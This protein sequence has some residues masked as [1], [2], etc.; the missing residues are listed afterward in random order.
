MSLKALQLTVLHLDGMEE[1]VTIHAGAQ[2]ASERW[3]LEGRG[4]RGDAEAA[5]FSAWYASGR[6]GVGSD[7]AAKFED[8]LPTI[9][10]VS[11]AEAESADPTQPTP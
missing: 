2:V 8:W 10:S 3:R 1:T 4:K 9:A 5:Y 11:P 6:P 7:D